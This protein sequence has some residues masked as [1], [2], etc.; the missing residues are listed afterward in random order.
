MKLSDEEWKKRL[1][2]DQYRVLRNKGTDPRFLSLQMP[3]GFDVWSC[4]GCGNPLFTLADKYESGSGWPSFT[5]PLREDSIEL[6][7]DSSYG[8]LRIEVVCS[9]CI[10]HLGHVFDDGPAPSSKR[11]CINGSALTG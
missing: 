11:F 7:S 3:N 1:T 6:R 5:R 10:G 8:M 4:A 9:I 2:P